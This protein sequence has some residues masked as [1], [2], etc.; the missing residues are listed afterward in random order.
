MDLC[1]NLCASFSVVSHTNIF[2]IHLWIYV[3]VSCKTYDLSHIYMRV[4]VRVFMCLCV[5]VSLSLFVCVWVQFQHF[6]S[7]FVF[8]MS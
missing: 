8:G 7:P 5:C 2:V 6:I 3:D 4:C 1:V